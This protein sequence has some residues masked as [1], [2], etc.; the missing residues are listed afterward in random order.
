MNA[1]RMTD[2]SLHSILKTMTRPKDKWTE[3]FFSLSSSNKH[4]NSN[5]YHNSRTEETNY[6]PSLQTHVRQFLQIWLKNPPAKAQR[7]TEQNLLVKCGWAVTDSPKTKWANSAWIS[8]KCDRMTKWD[9][10]VTKCP[11]SASQWHSNF[12][13]L[14]VFWL[15]NGN[16]NLGWPA[17]KAWL[18]IHIRIIVDH[19]QLM[20]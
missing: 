15:W 19:H 9:G 8:H 10:E 4:R 12:R 20:W 16:T 2:G 3:Q 18:L 5:N 7:W 17:L 1:L 13:H 14:T 11:R 6:Y